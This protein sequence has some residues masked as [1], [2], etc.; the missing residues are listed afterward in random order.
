MPGPLMMD[1][2]GLTLSKSEQELLTHPMI[3]GLILFSRN[4]QSVEQVK[5]LCKNIKTVRSD[6]LIAVDQEGGR[7]QRFK[8]GLTLLPA[9]GDIPSIANKHQLKES[10]LAHELGWLMALEMKY[11]GVD[12]SFAP[13]LDINR[14]NSQVIGNR[15]F[16]HDLETVVSLAGD[17]IDG[18]A[19]SHMAATGKHFP[20]HGGVVGDSHLELPV[21]SRKK[22]L[23]N[24]D[25]TVF[26]QL[27]GKLRGIMPAHVLYPKFDK[28]NPAGFSAFWLMQKLR[29]EL[30]F[31]G[32]I[33][34]D[35]LSMEGA[36]VFGTYPERA[37]KAQ[38][39]GCDM[40]LVCNQPEAVIEIIQSE[41]LTINEKS[42]QRIKQ[43]LAISDEQELTA[44]MSSARRHKLQQYLNEDNR[45][46]G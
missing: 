24:E 13:V 4:F 9:M 27:A 35:D 10:W 31:E 25:L 23:L 5:Q 2:E 17:F 11:L 7:V 29:Q 3:G 43:F 34:S 36:A 15:G 1:I 41:V 40:I 38:Q 28:I 6:I 8:T 20:G 32:V 37:L 44:L 39:A 42:E 12:I 22:E 33:F 19:E 45:G 46:V 16:G 26:S 14:N 18:M 21:D 30:Q